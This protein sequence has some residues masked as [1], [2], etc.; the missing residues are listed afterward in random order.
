MKKMTAVSLVFLVLLSAP[1]ASAC[2]DKLLHLSRIHRPHSAYASVSVVL[3]SRPDSALEE[4]TTLPLAKAFR[5]A[6]HRLQ[7]V[8]SEREL[9]AAIKSGAADVV[10]VDMADVP[11]V[12]AM[13]P[14]AALL[15]VPMVPKHAGRSDSTAKAYDAVIQSP[16]KP[17]KF[18]DAVDRALDAQWARQNSKPQKQSIFAR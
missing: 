3:F 9:I 13:D 7:L 17:G 16:A 4:A 1:G 14:P 11:L 5:G 10:I 8:A 18:V 2:G 15:L 12:R 6:G